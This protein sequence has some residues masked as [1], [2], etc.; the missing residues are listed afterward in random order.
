MKPA[1]PDRQP[2]ATAHQH[3]DQVWQSSTGRAAWS[4]ADPWVAQIVSTLRERGARRVLDVGCGV[5]RHALFLA[6]LGFECAA[7]DASPTAIE[8]ARAE[9]AAADL[10]VDLRLAP[11]D[12]LPYADG[13]FDYVLAYN[14]IYHGDAMSVRRALKEIHRVLSGGG[15]YQITML[16]ARNAGYGRGN[17]ISPG[18][19]VQPAAADDKVHPHFYCDAEEMLR[20]NRPAQLLSA[21]DWEHA[22]PGNFH[23]HCL[24]ETLPAQP[25]R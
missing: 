6:S 18:T 24:F 7:V 4:E 2:V 16:S 25:A 9:A 21:H 14:A 5:G 20:L 13:E 8:H 1:L 11:F 3:W 15:L 23:W 10:Q 22:E 17:L 12:E 19:F